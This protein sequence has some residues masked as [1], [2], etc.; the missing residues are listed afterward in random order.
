M[1]GRVHHAHNRVDFR[2]LFRLEIVLV[3]TVEGVLRRLF[4]VDVLRIR[5]MQLDDRGDLGVRDF[6]RGHDSKRESTIR[7]RRGVWALARVVRHVR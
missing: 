6:R 4:D 3:R 1:C 5:E 7:K 2:Y